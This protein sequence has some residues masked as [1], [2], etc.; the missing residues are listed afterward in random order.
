MEYGVMQ[1][2]GNHLI[3]LSYLENENYIVKD[4]SD[5]NAKIPSVA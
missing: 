3:N 4:K 1:Q 5:V 2:N